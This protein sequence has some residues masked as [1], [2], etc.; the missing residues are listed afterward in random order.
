[1]R[2]TILGNGILAN[3]AALYLRK[4]LPDEATITIVGPAERG[5][6]PLVGESLIE[7]TTRFLE[8][9]LGLGQY[10][11]EHHNPKF[12]LT[13]YFKLDL[14]DPD[15]RTYSVHCNERA[16]DNQPPLPGWEG[17]MARPPAWL[18]NRPVFDRDMKKLVTDNPGI[19]RIEG[20]AKDANLDGEAG[21][22]ITIACENG[23]E[24]S[25]DADWI[26]DVTGRARFLGK[27]LGLIDKPETGQRNCFWFHI[28]DFDPK[29]LNALDALGP[30]PPDV[31]ED[32]HYDRYFTTHH[33][34]GRGN[35]VWLIPVKGEDGKDMMSIGLTSRPDL[36]PHE[37]R[38]VDQFLEQVSEEHPVVTDLVESG[39]VVDTSILGNYRYYSRKA[40]SKDRWC[41]LGDAAYALD[42]LFSNGLAFGSMQIEQIGE[43]LTRDIAGKLTPKLIK[44]MDAAIWAPVKSSQEA[45]TNWYASM[46]DPYL[47]SLRLNWIEIAYF[48]LLLPM[49]VNRCHFDPERMILWRILQLS[50]TPYE[51]PQQLVDARD[52]FDRATPAHFI[53]RGT[54]KVN[55]RALEE[56]STLSEVRSQIEDGS[57]FRRRYIR[58]ALAQVEK[59]ELMAES[60]AIA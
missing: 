24:Q 46:H 21:H 20:V 14:E 50:D 10:L 60:A 49:V 6:L 29:L 27:R 56:A 47:C 16:P 37:V 13:Y 38:S 57:E 41:I 25:L 7:V 26:L 15:D 40:Y 44:E 18:L 42:P 12:A 54:E 5:G 30:K 4:K 43:M 58:D 53:Y 3:L 34:M 31:G 51:L 59:A 22:T 33:F 2:I 48:Y 55:R 36:Y 45:I 11:R 32:Y 1:M 17:P 39:T 8:E 19:Q 23:D 9:Q 35:W 52:S 28:R